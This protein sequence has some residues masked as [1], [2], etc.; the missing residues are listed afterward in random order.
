MQENFDDPSKLHGLE[1]SVS[2]LSKNLTKNLN[3]LP[4]YSSVKQNLPSYSIP[5]A[6]RFEEEKGDKLPGPMSYF[7]DKYYEMES[8][9]GSN[10]IA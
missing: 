7:Q 9:P 10:K 5:K 3:Q 8:K 4:N 2:Y 6:Y 1:Q